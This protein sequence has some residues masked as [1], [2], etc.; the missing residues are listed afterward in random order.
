MGACPPSR[1]WKLAF[2]SGFWGLS[3]SPPGLYLWT[4]LGD[5]RPHTPSFVPPVANSW[6]R[7]W[8]WLQIKLLH[9]CLIAFD[10]PWLSRN[11]AVERRGCNKKVQLSLTKR[12]T[13]AKSLHGLRKSSGV[14]RCIARLPIDWVPMVS[15]TSYIV[16][17]SVKCVAL[18]ILAF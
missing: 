5:I 16:T 12:A 15:I 4:P 1:S 18:E 8:P 13:L 9:K 3:R 7:P 2:I 6:L 14:V 11:I 10:L 17:V